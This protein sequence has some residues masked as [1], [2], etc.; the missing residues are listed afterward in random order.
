MGQLADYVLYLL[1][2]VFQKKVKPYS[3]EVEDP[4]AARYIRIYQFQL[5]LEGGHRHG[6]QFNHYE[7]CKLWLDKQNI[8][9]NY[10]IVRFWSVVQESKYTHAEPEIIND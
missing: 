10:K 2:R 4:K 9:G 3:W 7:E 6:P 1:L 8:K 5:E